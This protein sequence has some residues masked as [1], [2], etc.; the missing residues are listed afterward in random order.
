MI[1]SCEQNVL[2]QCLFSMFSGVTDQD[3]SG[4]N[5]SLPSFLDDSHENINITSSFSYEDSFELSQIRQS[6][7][8]PQV[9]LKRQ[10][11]DVS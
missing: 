7:P 8:S 5:E 4:L 9:Q 2:F 1:K 6:V 10:R 11:Q 3:L